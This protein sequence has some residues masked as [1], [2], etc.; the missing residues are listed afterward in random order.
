MKEKFIETQNYIRLMESFARLKH[1]PKT[2]PKIGLGYGNFG[3]GKTFALERITANENAV[4]MRAAQVWSKKSV[5]EQLCGELG[6]AT[7]D[8]PARMYQ[9]VLEEIRREPRPIIVDEVDAILR[10]DKYGVLEL[11]R[12][13]HDETGVIVF[14]IGMEEANAKL[15]RH[16]H[17]YSRVVEFVEFK[18]ITKE[19]IEKFCELS[20]IKIKPCLIDY[21]TAKYPNLR[22]IRVLLIRLEDA[23]KRNAIKECDEETFKKLGI[24]NVGR[25]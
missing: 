5:L 20:D 6:L 2:A 12:D 9:R 25:E 16:R 21:F 23:A 17:Y 3:L 10:G 11:F 15:K 13:I 4:L 1:L 14:M 7:T 19:D 8:G 24:E 22:Q 18:V